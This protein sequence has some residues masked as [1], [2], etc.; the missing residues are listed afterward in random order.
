MI[1]IYLKEMKND[2]DMI[3]VDVK[4]AEGRAIFRPSR[5]MIE[6][7]ISQTDKV[8]GM[9]RENATLTVFKYI[10]DYLRGMGTDDEIIHGIM[11]ATDSGLTT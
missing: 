6:S 8:T 11:D 4:G 2:K 5:I 9:G 3:L 10:L 1:E 7:A